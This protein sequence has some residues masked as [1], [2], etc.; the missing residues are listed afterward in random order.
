MF[1]VKGIYFLLNIYAIN[2]EMPVEKAYDRD[3]FI[4]T[5]SGDYLYTGRKKADLQILK[6][7]PGMA[8]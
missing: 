4:R 1:V 2:V 6:R 5:A 8:S 7:I 3:E